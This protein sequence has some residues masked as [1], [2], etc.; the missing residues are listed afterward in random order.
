[1]PTTLTRS[2]NSAGHL[3]APRYP[4]LWGDHQHAEHPTVLHLSAWSKWPPCSSRARPVNG[5]CR[6]SQN[7]T[8]PAGKQQLCVATKSTLL[9]SCP[10]HD[11]A[12][13]GMSARHTPVQCAL[14]ACGPPFLQRKYRRGAGA[15]DSSK[16]QQLA[17]MSRRLS[18]KDTHLQT[19]SGS[20]N[21]TAARR[22]GRP[23]SPRTAPVHTQHKQCLAAPP[24]RP[25]DQQSRPLCR[26]RAMSGRV[27]LALDSC[28][29][30]GRKCH[31]EQEQ[32]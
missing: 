10:V 9:L 7:S 26:D 2:C 22:P 30:G 28:V 11:V 15:S 12:A 21:G 20:R 24:E 13:S 4:L 31:N 19:S 27:H 25:A 29:R 18:D 8:M 6:S 3:S 5:S 23:A 32:P 14:A 16:G 1:M 17:D